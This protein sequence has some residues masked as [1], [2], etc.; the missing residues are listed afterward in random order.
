MEADAA[1]VADDDQ[2]VAERKLFG[3]AEGGRLELLGV[4][5]L[6]HRQISARIKAHHACGILGAVGGDDL[7]GV[8]GFAV[9]YHVRIGDDVAVGGNDDAAALG[10]NVFIL[11]CLAAVA[12]HAHHGFVDRVVGV[13]CAVGGVGGGVVWQGRQR[14]PGVVFICLV[15][16]VG[17]AVLG[18]R[19]FLRR[20]LEILLEFIL[21]KLSGGVLR[22]DNAV[23]LALIAAFLLL[24]NAD[25][26]NG[27]QAC[28]EQKAEHDDDNHQRGVRLGL[29][30]LLLRHGLRR[31]FLYSASRRKRR[32]GR[33]VDRRSGFKA[34]LRIHRCVLNGIEAV[35][36]RRRGLH[37]R[38]LR[39][40]INRLRRGR[41]ERL[42]GGRF[43]GERL[44]RSKAVEFI[45]KLIIHKITPAFLV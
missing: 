29:R 19:A 9:P 23:M 7:N 17:F 31:N 3:I 18:L 43:F 22:S 34:V 6:E 42:L 40:K 41:C 21:G 15:G 12:A 37:Q 1:G 28:R 20:R 35:L 33:L 5:E 2:I 10:G 4:V 38:L 24:Q 32:H 44:L 45:F 25:A 26:E 27:K 16:I 14:Q 39:L 30:R 8:G 11:A 36:L 13:A